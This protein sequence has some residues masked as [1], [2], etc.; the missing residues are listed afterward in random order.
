LLNKKKLLPGS[1]AFGRSFEHFIKAFLEDFPQAKAI[2]VSLDKYPG[3]LNGVE[4]IPAEQF[5]KLLW[6]NEVV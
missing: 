4:I 1:E 5:L 3:I 2:V 6:N